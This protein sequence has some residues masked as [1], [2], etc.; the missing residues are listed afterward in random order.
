MLGGL[1]SLAEQ[2]LRSPTP[3]LEVGWFPLIISIA[4]LNLP[5]DLEA[6]FFCLYAVHEAVLEDEATYLPRLFSPAILGRLPTEG[7][8]ALRGT[9]LRMVGEYAGWF[10]SQHQACLQAVSFV[11]PALSDPAL[12]AQ[13]ARSLRLLCTANRETLG[14]HV[15]SFVAVLG[16]LEGKVDVRWMFG[17]SL[18]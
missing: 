4:Q 13:A 12:C 2:Q 1:V 10:G 14:E 7:F 17:C 11:V 3:D 15:G 9:A 5:Q 18:R 6:V 8:T 16:G